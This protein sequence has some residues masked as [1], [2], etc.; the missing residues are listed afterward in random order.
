M[1][2]NSLILIYTLFIIMPLQAQTCTG[3]QIITGKDT[4]RS[5]CLSNN[6]MNWWSAFQWCKSNGRTLA[7]P[8]NACHY[9]TETGWMTGLWGCANMKQTSLP[10]SWVSLALDTNNALSIGAYHVNII[11]RTQRQNALCE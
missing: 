2:R 10:G 3:G 4:T 7:S 8:D 1:V 6:T 5:F 11:D 9:G